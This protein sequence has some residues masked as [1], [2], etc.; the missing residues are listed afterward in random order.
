MMYK[1]GQTKLLD[2]KELRKKVKLIKKVEL[3]LVTRKTKD[4]LST[5]IKKYLQHKLK[6][7][8][9]SNQLFINKILEIN[10]CRYFEV[11]FIR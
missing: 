5:Q 2:R 11:G 7:S 10:K 8:F 9:L 3:I 1:I 4:I 6:V